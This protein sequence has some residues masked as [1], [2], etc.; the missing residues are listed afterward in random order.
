MKIFAW[1][2][3]YMKGKMSLYCFSQIMNAEFYV[4]ILYM[5]LSKIEDLLKDE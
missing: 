1:E 4:N 5:Y 2:R 3:F